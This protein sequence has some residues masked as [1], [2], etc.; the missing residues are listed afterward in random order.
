MGIDNFVLALDA[1]HGL[2]TEGKRCLKSLDATETRE[3]V[4]NDRVARYIQERARQYEGFLT[5][6]MDDPTGRVD[7]SLDTRCS[8]A[9]VLGA[10]VYFSVH[11]NAGVNGQNTTKHDGGVVAFS[12]KENTAGAEMRNAVYDAVVEATGLVGNRCNPKTTADFYVLRNTDMPAVLVEFGFM[13]SP[14]DVPVILTDAFA[15]KCANAVADTFAK[16]NGLKFIDI[17]PSC[18]CEAVEKEIRYKG[19]DDAPGYVCETIS[20]L[21]ECGA[22]NGTGTEKGIDLNLDALRILT[23]ILRYIDCVKS[24][25]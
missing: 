17:N 1:G 9:N 4:L 12:Y 3:W 14:D 2:F 16:M 25:V 15:R 13:D 11:H 22:L 8:M 6:R 24:G 10:D 20:Q 21:M 23:I 7:I 18:E 19:L 5:Y